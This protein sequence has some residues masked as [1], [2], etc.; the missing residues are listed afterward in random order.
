MSMDVLFE[1]RGIDSAFNAANGN[2][3]DFIDCTIELGRERLNSLTRDVERAGK[4]MLEES[5]DPDR[6]EWLVEAYKTAKQDRNIVFQSLQCWEKFNVTNFDRVPCN[7]LVILFT[8]IVNH[9]DHDY[10]VQMMTRAA[11]QQLT[12]GEGTDWYIA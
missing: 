1:K 12:T 2:M 3:T 6:I 8:Y 7:Q 5:E 4:D 9:V 11:I 10:Y